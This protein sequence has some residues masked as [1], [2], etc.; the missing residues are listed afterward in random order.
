[1]GKQIKSLLRIQF[2]HFVT[3]HKKLQIQRAQ[4]Q[5]RYQKPTDITHS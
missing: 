3:D 4:I 5:G 2:M 1:M